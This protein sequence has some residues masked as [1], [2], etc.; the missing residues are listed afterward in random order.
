MQS[1]QNIHTPK[2]IPADAD[3]EKAEMDIL[4]DGLR[5]THTE[6]FLMMTTLM[7]MNTMFRKAKMRSPI[8]K[9]HLFTQT[10]KWESLLQKAKIL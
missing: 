1:N 10:L 6:R 8:E 2:Y 3:Y 4:R 9:L 7:K 5:R